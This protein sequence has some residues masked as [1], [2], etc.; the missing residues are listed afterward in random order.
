MDPEDGRTCYMV[1]VGRG[2]TREYQD[3]SRSFT[4]CVGTGVENHALLGDGIYC[5]SG[6]KLW[7]NLYAPSTADWRRERAQIEMTTDFPEGESATLRINLKSRKTFTLALR[8]PSWAGEGFS[9]AINGQPMPD[10]PGPASYVELNRRWK[11]GD[12]VPLTLPK[13][14]HAEPL[15]DNPRRAALLWGPLVLAGDLGPDERDDAKIPVPV[16]VAAGLPVEQWLKPKPGHS[17]EFISDGV[18]RE[19]DVDFV[20]FYRLH[21]RTYAAYWDLLTPAEWDDRQKLSHAQ[22][23]RN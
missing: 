19:H 15:A 16:F 12:L 6:D 20:P 1:P 7:I 21:R 2:V 14:L 4:C 18:G 23:N 11:D 22:N 8:R 3:M 13:R 5:E 9:V 17:D 10:L